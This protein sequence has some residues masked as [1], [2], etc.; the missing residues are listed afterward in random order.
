MNW[1]EKLEEKP[2]R[3]RFAQKVIQA[4]RAAGAAGTIDYDAD[5]F[6]IV[7]THEGETV[8]Q[9]QM[10][11]SNVYADYL[12]APKPKRWR[13]IERFIRG[14]REF[15]MPKGF[16]QVRD[17]LVVRVRSRCYYTLLK[18]RFG[19]DGSR[20]RPIVYQ[21]L[22][23]HLAVGLAVDQKDGLIEV[24]G[25]MLTAWGIGIDEAFALGKENLR[26]MSPPSLSSLSP[27]LYCSPRGDNHDA[28]RLALD[29][30]VRDCEVKGD[31]VAMVPNRDTLL[32]TGADDPYNLGAILH[33]GEK[34]L[35]DKPR[36]MSGVPVRLRN[37]VWEP[38]YPDEIYPELRQFRVL[39]VRNEAQ[40]YNEQQELLEQYHSQSEK[41]LFV[42]SYSVLQHKET[43]A[44]RSYT[45]WGD[46]VK[47]LLPRAEMVFFMHVNEQG[48]G[49]VVGN[50]DW[51]HVCEVVGHRMQPT[52]DYPPRFLVESFP[53]E[54]EL[55]RLGKQEIV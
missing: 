50:A 35:R 32:I 51:E 31:Y 11:L 44:I 45:V 1:W 37:G 36:P 55:Q 25:D 40:D 3:D 9:V 48:G 42:A 30:L 27:G 8:D 18:L 12:A 5:K 2:K 24:F 43:G 17:H 7:L 13:V 20:Q 49:G 33:I 52:D 19:K 29:D 34:I 16:E 54:D 53:T 47:S 4:L 6:Q 14:T 21:P 46:C 39:R 10:N 15:E 41:D 26:R 38:F 22:G 28:S 23:E